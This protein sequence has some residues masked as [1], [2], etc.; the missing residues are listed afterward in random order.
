MS[1]KQAL[2]TSNS[3]VFTVY[4]P[5]DHKNKLGAVKTYLTASSVAF[6]VGVVHIEHYSVNSYHV[7]GYARLSAVV[8]SSM[9]RH[10]EERRKNYWKLSSTVKEVQSA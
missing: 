8:S 4:V 10:L 1:G 6:I 2:S 9:F 7:T 5:L 3:Y